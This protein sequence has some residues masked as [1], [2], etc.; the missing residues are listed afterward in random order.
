MPARPDPSRLRF[1]FVLARYGDD[2]LGGAEKHA[3]DVCERLAARG[4]DVRVL[5]TCAT[6]YQTWRNE[7]TMGRDSLRGV[8]IVRYPILTG[9]IPGLDDAVKWVASKLADVRALGLLWAAIQGP[10]VPG[11]VRRLGREAAERDLLVFF[12][13][14]STLSFS[15]MPRV[16]HKSALVPLVHEEPPI[17]TKIARETLGVPAALLVNTEEEWARIARVTEGRAAPG[18]V[19][20]VGREP[21]APVDPSFRPPTDR[22]YLLILGRAGKTRPML[23]VWRE[24][25]RAASRLPPLELADGRTVPWSEV[26]LVTVGEPSRMYGD[27]EGVTQL[28]FVSDSDRWQLLRGATAIVNPSRYESLSLVLLEAWTLGLPVIVNERCDV[29]VGQCRRS[30][31]GVALD[32][33]AP[34]RAALELAEALASRASRARMGEGGRAY[35]ESRYDWDRVCRAYESTALAVA[36]GRPMREALASWAPR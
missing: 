8:E 20:A 14:L 36:S 22:P 29:T 33:E 21:P 23:A 10:G 13:L 28:P 34:E 35:S 31:G 25:R 5:T 16:R 12:S 19:V 7:L 27:L 15:A 18:A 24:L 26:E 30:G 32:F 3:R 9:R 2:V 6:S 11:L 17:Y 4:H 1:T